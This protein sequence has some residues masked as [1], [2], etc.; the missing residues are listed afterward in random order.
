MKLSDKEILELNELCNALLDGTLS[1]KQKA[2]LGEF[3]RASSEACQFYVRV[4]GLS[5]S[6]IHYAGEMQTAVPE[7][8]AGRE[9]I[10]PLFTWILGGLAAAAC[11]AV[12]VWIGRPQHPS[13][14]A[15]SHANEFVA[16]LTGL[17][18]CGWAHTAPTSRIGDRLL[19]GQRLDIAAG[20][21]EITFDSGAQIV[22]EGPAALEVKSAWSAALEHG[23]VK[24]SV[25]PQAIG[26]RISNPSVEVVDLGTEFTMSAEA[27]GEAEVLVLKGQVEA[28]PTQSATSDRQPIVLREKE[29]RRFAISGI[30]NVKGSQEKF[31]R[32]A[33]PISLDHFSPPTHL[34][35]WAFDES[36][37]NVLEADAFGLPVPTS[38]AH[39]FETFDLAVAHANGRRH[40]ALRF[41][42]HFYAGAKFPGIAEYAPHTVVFWLKLGKDANLANA[43]AMVAWG[44]NSQRLGSHPIHIGWN[45]NPGEATVGVLRT[46]YG[47]GYAVGST[48]LRDGRWHHV[49]VVLVPSDDAGNPLAVN[50]YVDGRLEGEGRPS[51]PGSDVFMR[52][53]GRMPNDA[54]WLGCRIGINDVRSERF[55]GEMDEMFIA[56]RALE[57]QEIVCLMEHNQLQ[58]TVAAA[59][60]SEATGRKE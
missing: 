60:N 1:D 35:H 9:K 37:G 33:Q 54:L 16:R 34:L 51:A 6:L 56:D 22:L 27:T 24:A 19:K 11:V 43:Y 36:K 15:E 55:V 49:A 28:Q 46:D 53:A 41:D 38:S 26:F 59:G 5:A 12:L 10:V 42:G 14:P 13:T 45:R 39:L 31:A 25:P 18:E 29:S 20:F 4:M 32:M 48:S 23:T 8:V 44:V 17:K 30:S 2:R 52:S 40:G 21:V 50:Q 57:P 7:R 3:L 47:G 58:L